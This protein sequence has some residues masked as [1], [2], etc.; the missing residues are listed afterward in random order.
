MERET[1]HE[2]DIKHYIK[3]KL[4]VVRKS[5]ETD[6]LPSEIF[7]KSANIF[8]R[9]VLVLD[10][11]TSEYTTNPVPIKQ[12]RTRLQDIPSELNKLFE[13]ILTRDGK[14][15]EQLQACFKWVL[16]AFRPLKPQ[17]FCIAIR[18]AL[19]P[20]SSTFWEPEGDLNLEEM[21]RFVRTSSK[22]LVEF[23][24]KKASEVQFIH[25]S[26][27]DFLLG[28]YNVQWSGASNNFVSHGHETLR[29]C[30][31]AQLN[32]TMTKR[33]FKLALPR[34]LEAAQLRKTISLEFPLL[35]Y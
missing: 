22:G 23:T 4:R 18:L 3:S 5:K 17:E 33:A 13:M 7:E 1:G 35:E 31:L 16:F 32:A 12:L 27:R 14:N 34:D 21:K 2:E 24:H 9:V 25:E 19:D 11:L 28:K 26:A 20:K 10:I 30:C 6:L 29:G 15:P 8:L